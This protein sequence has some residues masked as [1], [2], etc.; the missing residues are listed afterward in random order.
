A[1]RLRGFLAEVA[2]MTNLDAHGKAGLPADHA[3]LTTVHQAKGMEWPVVILP[4]VTDKL[5]P[6]ARSVE[7]G[8]LDEERRLFYVAVTRAKD[9]L[10]ICSPRVRKT[11]EGGVMPCDDSPF[12]R[13]VPPDLY[14]E[15]F[16]RTPPPPPG[17]QY[18]KPR[19]DM[20]GGWGKPLRPPGTRT[21]WRR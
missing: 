7:E 21:A 1:A 6:A 4:W 3:H 8:N 16:F 20:Y 11:P 9:L 14:S 12:L 19:G 2:L 17:M 13:D 15:R 10:Y 5:F 18:G